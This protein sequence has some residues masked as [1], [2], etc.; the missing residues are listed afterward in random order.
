MDG[1]LYEGSGG[2]EEFLWY[3]KNARQLSQITA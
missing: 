2:G 1:K 3:G